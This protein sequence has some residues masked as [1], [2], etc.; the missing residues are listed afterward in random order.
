MEKFYKLCEIHTTAVETVVK[1]RVSRKTHQEI[2]SC[3]FTDVYV[4]AMNVKSNNSCSSY[5]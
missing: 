3:S 2:L 5:Q 1:E 4:T